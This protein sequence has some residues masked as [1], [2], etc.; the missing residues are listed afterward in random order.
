MGKFTKVFVNGHWIGGIADPHTFVNTVKI[1]RRHGLIP[2]TM[3][4][5]FDYSRNSILLSTDGGR[6]CRPIFYRDE[7]EH[8]FA[9]NETNAWKTVQTA[10]DH[11]FTS[12]NTS[13]TISNANRLWFQLVSGFH[14]KKIAQYNPYKN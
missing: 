3:S 1:H 2:I 9:F 7:V 5:M 6:L 4:I 14:E 12:S 10:V 11:Y 13:N 8:N